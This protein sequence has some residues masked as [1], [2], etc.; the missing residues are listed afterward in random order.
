MSRT[1]TKLT[2][3]GV[4]Y[5]ITQVGAETGD[6]ILFRVGQALA[7][8]LTATSLADILVRLMRNLS[9]E[10]FVWLRNEM[11]K[12]TKVGIV[13][14]VGDGRVTFTPL[15]PLY[16]DHFA[17]RYMAAL[18]WLKGALESNFGAFFVEFIRRAQSAKAVEASASENPKAAAGS[19]GASSSASG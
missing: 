6:A 9:I 4:V 18:E 13:D 17:G 14:T 7:M 8:S 11:K 5:E 15:A 3:E 1:V 16:D 10:D 2:I 12:C 19:S